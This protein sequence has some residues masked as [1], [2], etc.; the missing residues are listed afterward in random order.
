[1]LLHHLRETASQVADLYDRL[2]MVAD[3]PKSTGRSA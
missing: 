2:L 3:G 1:V